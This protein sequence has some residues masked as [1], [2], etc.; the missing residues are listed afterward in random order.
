M[1]SFGSSVQDADGNLVLDS[2]ETLEALSYVKAL[3]EETMTPEVLAWDASS[4]NRFMI[5]GKGSLALNAI[6][7]TRT[8]ESQNN[9]IGEKIWLAKA[10]QGPVRR[11]GLEH[12]MDVYVIWQF[13]QNIDGAKQFLVDYIDNFRQGF[14]ASEFYNFP[15]FPAT[16]PDL[17]KQI[18]HDPRASPPDKYKV[19]EDVLDWATNVGYPGYATAAIDEVFNTW[20]LNTMFAKAATGAETPEDALKAA[21]AECQ[22][23]WTKWQERG[24]I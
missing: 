5:A 21:T 3:F 4:N 9:P 14:L 20:V 23:I 10:A 12:V 8:A 17:K 6:S 16:V 18:A 2:R 1:Y 11:I 7:I 13:A 19:L 24:F 22:R 15:C